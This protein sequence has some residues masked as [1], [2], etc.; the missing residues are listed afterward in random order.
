MGLGVEGCYDRLRE[1]VSQQPGPRLGQ[2]VEMELAGGARAQRA[3][4]HHRQHP[5]PGRGLQHDVVRPDGGS[6]QCRIGERQRCGELLEP[7]L[8]FRPPGVGGLQRRDRFQHRQHPARP[9]CAGAAGAAHAPSRSAGGTARTPPRRPR[10]RPSR[11]SRPGVGCAEGLRH[12][13]PEGRGIHRPAGLQHR[14]Q[15]PGRGEQGIARGGTGRRCGRF[16]R[17]GGKGRTREGVRRRVG[18][19]HGR[20][21]A[22]GHRT[23]VGWTRNATPAPLR[24]TARNRPAD[25]S[26]APAGRRSRTRGRPR[27]R[28]Q[29]IG[30]GFRRAGSA[31]SRSVRRKRPG[32]HGYDLVDG[33]VGG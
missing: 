16:D 23:G 13:V 3:L 1:Q 29:E 10:R 21:R 14:Q 4:R 20:L 32:I 28:V 22:E 26:V 6:L 33:V 31:E 11:P 19:E 2:F 24:R 18:V 7:D 9:V 15:G 8:L 30:G 12:G 25:L 17:V 5:G 27:G